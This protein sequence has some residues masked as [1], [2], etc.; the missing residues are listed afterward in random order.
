[1]KEATG[2]LR[3]QDSYYHGVH[4]VELKYPG[5]G[6]KKNKYQRDSDTNMLLFGHINM[7]YS[8]KQWD[9]FTQTTKTK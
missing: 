3:R 8:K 6:A 7:S 2:G 9:I 4:I 1:M 5:S